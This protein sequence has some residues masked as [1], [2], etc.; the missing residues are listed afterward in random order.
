MKQ[1]EAIKEALASE[2]KSYML[3]EEASSKFDDAEIFKNIN[4]AEGRHILALEKAAQKYGIELDEG[5]P[6]QEA[7]IKGG[8]EEYLE[9]MIVA[10]RE[11]IE[12]YNRLI[13]QVE[14]ENI[15]E[16]FF[17][18]QA[19]SYNNHL[20]ALREHLYKA[21]G[22]NGQTKGLNEA[23]QAAQEF[24]KQLQGG[25][26]EPEIL[27]KNIGTMVSKVSGDFLLGALGG[28]VLGAILGGVVSKKE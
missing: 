27:Q 25:K 6:V 10:E 7:E 8:V 28:A 24:L 2:Y 22:Q 3:Y 5:E 4:N 26:I 1:E 21:Y 15:R 19:A 16:I 17:R 11:N 20:P 12:M 9:A 14:D 13:P 18:L 23:T